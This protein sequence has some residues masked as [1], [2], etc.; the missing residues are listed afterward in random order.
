MIIELPNVIMIQ[1]AGGSAL[2]NV[3]NEY[4]S[5]YLQHESLLGLP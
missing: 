2:M 3:Q 1:G 4:R 5:Q